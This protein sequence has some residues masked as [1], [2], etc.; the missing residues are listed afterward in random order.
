MKIQIRISIEVPEEDEKLYTIA[1][2]NIVEAL[3]ELVK[4][5]FPH[6]QTG[7]LA[8]PVVIVMSRLDD[9]KNL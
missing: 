5:E 8:S 6:F 4:K 7:K 2:E 9:I 1:T 3:H